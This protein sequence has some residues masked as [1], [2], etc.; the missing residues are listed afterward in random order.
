MADRAM[1]FGGWMHMLAQHPFEPIETAGPEA[2][3][4]IRQVVG[5]KDEHHLRHL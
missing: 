1:A 3:V 5:V 4:G 2:F